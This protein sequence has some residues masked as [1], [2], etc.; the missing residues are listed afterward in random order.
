MRKS[1]QPSTRGQPKQT[2]NTLLAPASLTLSSAHLQRQ[3]GRSKRSSGRTEKTARSSF[4]LL[5]PS[6]K[7]PPTCTLSSTS[8]PLLTHEHLSYYSEQPAAIKGMYQQSIYRPLGISAHLA[9]ARLLID[10]TNEHIKYPDA[11]SNRR[12]S[13]DQGDDD[14]NAHESYFNPEPGFAAS[15]CTTGQCP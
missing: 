5:G 6:A 4:K 12:K 1:Q 2:A 10:R 3:K 8:W 14:A 9:W 15:E 11:Q 7:C 13:R